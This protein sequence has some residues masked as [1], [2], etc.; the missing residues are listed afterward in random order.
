MKRKTKAQSY[1]EY[2]VLIALVAIAFVAL[3]TY[4]V[5][6]VQEKYRQSADVFGEG[7]Q[8][9]KG[10]TNVTEESSYLDIS[11][12]PRGRDICSSVVN[13]VATLEKEING[14]DQEVEGVTTHFQG[15]LERAAS[16]AALAEQARQNAQVLLSS[17]ATGS[18]EQVKQIQELAAE[19]DKEADNLRQEAE[20][21]QDQIDQLKKDYADCF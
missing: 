19:F 3:R 15:L 4:F 5:R 14:Y 12:T 6:A 2:G 10:I 20:E 1:L 13:Q 18:I 16:F 7:A 9:A 21:K 17:G 8:Y 11:P